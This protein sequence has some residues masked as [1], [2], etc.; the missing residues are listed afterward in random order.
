MSELDA[1]MAS[2][3][4]PTKGSFKNVMF[5]KKAARLDE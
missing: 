3:N 2:N 1:I 5:N 4:A